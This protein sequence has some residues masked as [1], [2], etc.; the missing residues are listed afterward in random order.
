LALA[1]AAAAKNH[2]AAGGQV[3]VTIT[4]SGGGFGRPADVDG[5]IRA[6]Q[7]GQHVEGPVKSYGG[8]RTS[9]TI[10]IA[11]IGSRSPPVSMTRGA[12][13]M[14]PPLRRLLGCSRWAPPWFTDGLDPDSTEGPI[15][16][17]Y[18]LQNM[19]V[20]YVRDRCRQAFQRLLAQRPALPNNVFVVEASGR[21]S[22]RRKTRSGGYRWLFS[23]NTRAKAV[24]RL[25]SG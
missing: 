14:E 25:S 4:S 5:V 16:L 3:V 8:E 12:C 1:Q 19:H 13:R 20:D 17:V 15:D 24:S 22:G 18:A 9:S 6:V 7:I 23:T 11:L 2:G 21:A 10:C